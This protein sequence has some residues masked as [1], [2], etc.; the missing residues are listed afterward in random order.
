M[1]SLTTGL[2]QGQHEL[3]PLQHAPLPVKGCEFV[4]AQIDCG[5]PAVMVGS[6]R[7]LL[8]AQ[9]TGAAIRLLARA[10]HGIAG[11]RLSFSVPSGSRVQCSKIIGLP[12][13]RSLSFHAILA[14]RYEA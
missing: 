10:R 7:Q 8:A 9:R 11:H 12:P 13:I 2:A 14:I 6:F 3:A 4:A 1:A 5:T